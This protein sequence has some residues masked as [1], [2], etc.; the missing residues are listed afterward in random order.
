MGSGGRLNQVQ[1][2]SLPFNSCVTIDTSPHTTVL[3]CPPRMYPHTCNNYLLGSSDSTTDTL[4]CVEKIGVDMCLL[5]TL[6]KSLPTPR[7][8]KLA[9]VHSLLAWAVGRSNYFRPLGIL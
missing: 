7:L 4:D 5:E 3:I 9:T 2:L 8:S 6:G 1:I